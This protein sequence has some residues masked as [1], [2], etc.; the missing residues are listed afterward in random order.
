MRTIRSFALLILCCAA[1]AHNGSERAVASTRAV[2]E[3]FAAILNRDIPEFREK[4][5]PGGFAVVDGRPVNFFVFNLADTTNIFPLS[6][7]KSATGPFVLNAR[8]VYHFAP[9]RLEVSFSHIGVLDN[10]QL[11][12][13]RFL[14]CEG[15]GDSVRDVVKYLT[16][17]GS[18]SDTVI[19]RVQNY[20]SYG[21]YFQTDPQSHVICH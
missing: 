12:V 14:N 20:R 6:S 13:F 15:K 2:I 19:A 7:P 5:D 10:G 16:Q 9:L 17:N 21:R 18:F 11:K 1:C 4:Y 8:G 3:E